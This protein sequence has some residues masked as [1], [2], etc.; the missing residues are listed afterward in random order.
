MKKTDIIDLSIS[1]EDVPVSYRVIGIGD[2]SLPIIH[3][4]NSVG[5][6]GVKTLLDKGD[7]IIPTDEDKMVI[8]INP[9][10]INSNI[11]SKAFYQ[12]N[13][14]TL[15]IASKGFAET[16]GSYDSLTEVNPE[17][18]VE[19]VKGL[20]DPLFHLSYTSF[21]FNDLSITLKDSRRFS[22]IT[23]LSQAN[24]DRFTAIVKELKNEISSLLRIKNISFI[25]SYNHATE[26]P[27]TMDEI[28]PLTEFFQKFPEETNVIWGIQTDNDLQLNQI[29]VTAILSGKDLKL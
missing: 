21:D 28:Q 23:K 19:T 15:I 25:I 22:V 17:S 16:T 2:K 8:I 1:K 20:L 9:E 11:L 29:K 6:P 27:I 7:I 24:S 14:L 3:E 10:N 26:I 5:Y 13:I 12:G 4:I 18:F